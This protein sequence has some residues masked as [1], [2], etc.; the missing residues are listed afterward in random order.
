[1]LVS[2]LFLLRGVL[3]AG[4]E[5]PAPDGRLFGVVM[6]SSSRLPVEFANIALY[7][8][9]DSSLVTGGITDAAGSFELK[10]LPDGDY[11]LMV[12]FIGYEQMT[13]PGIRIAP[14]ER[15][16]NLGTIMMG[17][18]AFQL[19]EAEVVATKSYTEYKLDRKVINVDQDISNTGASAAQVLEKSPAVRVDIEG[20]VS[21]RGSTN[22]IVFIDGKPS[23]LDGQEALQQIP[24][25]TIEN[26]EIITN[27]SVKYD[28]DG[29]S[30]I[31]NINLKK[32]K[33]KG[34]SGIIDLTAGTGDKYAGDLYLNYKTGRFNFYGGIDW[35][36]R[37]F[38]GNSFATRES[39]N[40]DTTDFREAANELIMSRNGLNFKGGIDYY[41]ADKT[42]VSVGGEYGNGGFGFAN[43]RD[44]H[45]YTP[46]KNYE[47]YFIDDNTIEWDRYFYSLNAG[48]VQQFRQEGHEMR[49]FAFYSKR[50]GSQN[51]DKQETDTDEN[52]VPLE[53]D[54]DLIRSTEEGPTD[55]IR[56]ELDYAKPVFENGK[57]EAGYHYRLDYDDESSYLE[58]Y[59]YQA[60]DWAR[61]EEFTKSSVFDR[62]IHAVFGIFS[63]EV[64]GF[65]Y[66][67]GLR[68][69][70]TYRSIDV[71]SPDNP[72]QSSVLDRF[73][74]FP[75]VHVSK[76]LNEV[77]Q[78]M[79]SYSR[80]IE[81]PRGHYLEPFVMYI[82]E[83]TRRV[84]NPDLLPEYTDSYELGYLRAFNAGSF[85]IEAYY[86]NTRDKMTRVTYYDTASQYF[87][88]TFYNVNKEKALGLESSFIYDIT[89]WFNLNLSTT[90][91]NYRLDD[92][93]GEN[94]EY[95]S[96]NNWDAR[97]IAAFKLPTNTAF[98][99]NFTYNG[100]SITAQGRAESVYYTDL[101]LRQEFFKRGLGITLKLSDVFAT[102]TSE[103]WT[104]GP[105]FQAYEYRERESRV[106]M[107]TLSYRIN[108]FKKTAAYQSSNVDD[109]AGM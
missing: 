14:K 73:D 96:S 50:D 27:P 52:Y 95:R 46:M 60:S 80:R 6:D 47:R 5:I 61:D 39:Y 67:L 30:G 90:F 89:K 42:T 101:T 37:K 108:N 93:T 94:A 21:L 76:S 72:P 34:F 62:S 40:G 91:Y 63:H 1:M 49:F 43:L 55:N 35:N 53:Q 109:G 48:L 33:L 36:D 58:Y 41:L 70:Y 64:V 17:T 38:R 45:D 25:N 3:I 12:Q 28:P 107:V 83:N 54:P 98:Q 4:E 31:I 78:L 57:F 85:N 29:T 19:Q 65:Q 9:L 68:G 82:D 11:Y 88:N 26:I 8:S 86:R 97:L 20:N 87:I 22:F 23:V 75:S 99:V 32:N 106:F 104:S 59:D 71:T 16:I 103:T 10:H 79:A 18:T 81:R 66:Q 44:V 77:N 24:A 100:P 56:I 2:L 51:Q 13:I 7:N 15:R 69:E 74:Y 92:L 105:N 102:N 84:G